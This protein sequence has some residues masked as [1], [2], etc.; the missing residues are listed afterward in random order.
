MAFLITTG[1]PPTH[2]HHTPRPG[3][4]FGGSA[5]AAA[6]PAVPG[7]G[8]GAAPFGSPFPSATPFG[9][10]AATNGGLS[11]SNSKARSGKKR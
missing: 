3:G 9:A 11:R 5:Q 2:N 7:L 8:G 1:A 10:G 6:A 4:M